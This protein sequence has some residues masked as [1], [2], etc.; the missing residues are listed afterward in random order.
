MGGPAEKGKKVPVYFSAEKGMGAFGIPLGRV[1]RPRRTPPRRFYEAAGNHRAHTD[2]GA[3][4]LPCLLVKLTVRTGGVAV[5]ASGIFRGIMGELEG[6]CD[7]VR[8]FVDELERR[9]KCRERPKKISAQ[10][11]SSGRQ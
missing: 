1:K 4:L 2:G 9:G 7:D 8:L 6:L 11:A 10:E 5:R 3:T